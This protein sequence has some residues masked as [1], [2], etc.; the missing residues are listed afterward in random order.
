MTDCLPDILFMA[1]WLDWMQPGVL[2]IR[3]GPALAN[4]CISIQTMICINLQIGTFLGWLGETKKARLGTALLGNLRAWKIENFSILQQKLDEAS[5]NSGIRFVN[6][7]LVWTWQ[8]KLKHSFLYGIFMKV[9]RVRGYFWTLLVLLPE[10]VN[11]TVSVK[12]GDVK[13]YSWQFHFQILS[14][15]L[16]TRIN[17]LFPLNT[18]IIIRPDFE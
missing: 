2:T 3:D 16:S 7:T 14:S 15:F 6:F 8:L 11:L 5:H 13:S 18:R 1:S 12:S 10:E 4:E 9:S 17:F